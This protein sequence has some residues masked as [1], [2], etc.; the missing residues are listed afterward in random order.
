MTRKG[1]IDI[2]ERT[3]ATFVVA[4]ISSYSVTNLSDWKSA[5]LAGLAAALTMVKSTAVNMTVGK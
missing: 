5:A 2:A 4:F 1:L 3:G